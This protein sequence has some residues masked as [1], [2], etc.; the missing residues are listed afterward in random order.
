MHEIKI[1][2]DEY[3]EA[4]IRNEKLKELISKV[5]GIKSD[6]VRILARNAKKTGK[7][8]L[9]EYQI[10]SVIQKFCKVKKMDDIFITEIKQ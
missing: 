7:G 9:T 4:V 8:K 5:T 6:S 10:V 2:K 1:L 3:I